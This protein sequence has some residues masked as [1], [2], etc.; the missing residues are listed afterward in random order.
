M[1]HVTSSHLW[2]GNHLRHKGLSKS[3]DGCNEQQQLQ[4]LVHL[5]GYEREWERAFGTFDYRNQKKAHLVVPAQ[6][7]N[8]SIAPVVEGHDERDKCA[9]TVNYS[10]GQLNSPMGPAYHTRSIQVTVCG[11]REVCGK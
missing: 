2:D 9:C 10:S 3:T 11:N 6:R 8:D 4:R 1:C 5:S 7:F